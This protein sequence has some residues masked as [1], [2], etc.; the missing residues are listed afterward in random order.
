MKIIIPLPSLPFAINAT[1][2]MQALAKQTLRKVNTTGKNYQQWSFTHSWL[3][4]A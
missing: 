2:K 1:A 3:Q 4:T